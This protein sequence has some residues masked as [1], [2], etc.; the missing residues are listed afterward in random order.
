MKFMSPSSG[1]YSDDFGIITSFKHKHVPLGIIN[2][3]PFCVDNCAFGGGFDER[4]FFEHLKK[5]EPYKNNCLFVVAPDAVGD[6]KET[7]SMY[8]H[9]Y[10]KIDWP[11]AFVAQ[12]AQENFNFPDNFDCL[13]IG[14]STEWKTSKHA[15]GV[16]KRAQTL[17]KHIHIG[18]VNW[19][20][21][22]AHFRIMEGSEN[23]TCDGTRP[24]FCG[25]EK[26]AKAWKGYMSQPPLIRV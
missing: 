11:I 3:M 26:T 19:W 14:G 4:K 16:I 12:D 10:N 22:Y 5:L 17:G 18:R 24:R 9:W 15:T 7:L 1:F 8:E 25:R 23:F 20:K 13:F 6:A 2:G 21:R